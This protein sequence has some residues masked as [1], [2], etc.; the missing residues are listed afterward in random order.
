MLLQT[1]VLLQ[2]KVCTLTSGPVSA[3]H[4][5]RV[6]GQHRNTAVDGGLSGL[7]IVYMML[8]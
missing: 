7:I 2:S 6:H 4:H 1:A 8:A 3:N 5:Q